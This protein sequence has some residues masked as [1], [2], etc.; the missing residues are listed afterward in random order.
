M[1]GGRFPVNSRWRGKC[2]RVYV[3]GQSRPVVSW[4]NRGIDQR[5]W[6]P[7][8]TQVLVIAAFSAEEAAERAAVLG[9]DLMGGRPVTVDRVVEKCDTGTHTSEHSLLD[10]R[11]VEVSWDWLAAALP[12]E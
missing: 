5:F 10:H 7:S 2:Y 6:H 3:T 12:G 11:G 1:V 8:R 4:S 9:A